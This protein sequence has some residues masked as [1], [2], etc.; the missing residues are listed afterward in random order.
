MN[1]SP[2][3]DPDPLAALLAVSSTDP[4]ALRQDL[5]LRTTRVVRR[6]RWFRRGAIVATLA[7][8]YVGGLATMH[9]MAPPPSI[10]E[11]VVVKEIDRSPLPPIVQ[12]APQEKDTAVAL[13]WNALDHPEKMVDSYHRAGDRYLADS[14]DIEAAMRCYKQMLDACSEKDLE[15]SSDDNWLLMALKEARQKERLHANAN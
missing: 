13:E 2:P 14:N 8:C 12:S 11:V 1:D 4:T 9:W 7:V 5:L 15:I 6:R 3:L 10:V